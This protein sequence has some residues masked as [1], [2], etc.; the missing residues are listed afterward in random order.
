MF[1]PGNPRSGSDA[2]RGQ[3]RPVED[4]RAPNAAERVRTLV[5]SSV[6]AVL[7]IPGCRSPA[8]STLGEGSP[9]ARA[10]NRDGDVVL[11]LPAS[12]H[13][14]EQAEL[15]AG[16]E[17]AAVMEITDVAPV[18]MPHR[19][20]ARAWI[21]G[22]LTVVRAEERAACVRLLEGQYPPVPP[23]DGAWQLLRLEVGEAYIDDM[24]GAEQ[25]EPDDFAQ[26]A[27]DPLA[28]HE[29][30]LLQ[31]LASSHDEEMRTLRRLLG[32][33]GQACAAA[34]GRAVPLS[35]DRYGMRVRFCDVDEY[36]AD[37]CFDAQF[38]FAEPVG[39]VT[40]LL[41]A[42]RLIFDAAAGQ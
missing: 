25:V 10:V 11:L 15:A 9:Q 19:R 18:A 41:R 14:V 27:P 12:S 13:V 2:D 5:D 22:W 42:M 16:E 3:P 36:G 24:C 1:R 32:A 29:A 7:D 17:V 37:A 31:H 23:A 6:S 33:P 28:P 20:R 4:A 21:A 38:E 26:A 34:C 30:A 8:P 40:G 39:D 35:V